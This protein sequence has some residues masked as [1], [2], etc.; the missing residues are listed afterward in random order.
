M[1]LDG[2]VRS[3]KGDIRNKDALR[4]ALRK[5]DFKSTRGN[6]KFNKNQFPVQDFYF[7]K[8]VKDGNSY[9]HSITGKAFANHQDRFVSQCKM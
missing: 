2:A 5:A 7:A 9:V 8:V 6:F 4:A 1:L 3:V